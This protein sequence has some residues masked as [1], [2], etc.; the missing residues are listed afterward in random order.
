MAFRGAIPRRHAGVACVLLALRIFRILH[1]ALFC[2]QRVL[3]CWNMAA[4]PATGTRELNGTSELRIARQQQPKSKTGG[5]SSRHLALDAAVFFPYENSAEVN[6]TYTATYTAKRDHAVQVRTGAG[7]SP[8]NGFIL[9]G[10]SRTHGFLP[11]VGI[12][13]IPKSKLRL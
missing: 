3:A 13:F 10:R 2:L 11:S 4:K 1:C 6:S 12:S 8:R 5:R 9:P 7:G